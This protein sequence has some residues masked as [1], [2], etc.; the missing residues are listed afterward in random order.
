MEQIHDSG[1]LRSLGEH[2][3]DKTLLL[4]GEAAPLLVSKAARRESCVGVVS[5]CAH[6]LSFTR[7]CRI[8]RHLGREIAMNE[9]GA[10]A[11]QRGARNALPL[12]EIARV[13]LRFNHIAR[14][15]NPNHRI[16]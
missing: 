3:C 15:V 16:M 5:Q 8:I 12:F 6:L 4:L 2:R 13:L 7:L 14:I 10:T 1:D 11:A 9:F